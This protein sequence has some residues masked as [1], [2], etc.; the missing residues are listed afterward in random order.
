MRPE[1]PAKKPSRKGQGYQQRVVNEANL[2]HRRDIWFTS[3]T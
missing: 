2:A 3:E 1:E